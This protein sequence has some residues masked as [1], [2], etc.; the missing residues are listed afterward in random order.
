[1]TQNQTTTGVL[2]QSTVSPIK[3][4]EQMKASG[5]APAK[6][7]Y[8]CKYQ[9]AGLVTWGNDSYGAALRKGKITKVASVDRMTE[10]SQ[11]LGTGRVCTVVTGQ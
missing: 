6:Y 10:G 1:M 2:W 11:V 5:V 8:S 9:V 3:P 7:G 4:E